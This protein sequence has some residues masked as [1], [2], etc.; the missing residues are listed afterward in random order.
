MV[1]VDAAAV[2]VSA[3][4]KV[5][6][7]GNR[8]ADARSPRYPA[9]LFPSVTA[10][11]DG[12]VVVAWLDNRFDPDPLWT[13]HTPPAGQP[14]SG[15]THPDNWQILAAVRTSGWS[16]PVAV[17][18]V[19]DAADRHPSVAAQSDGTL[20]AIWESKALQSS[21]ASLGLRSS[22]SADGGSTRSPFETVALE[23]TAMSQRARL[24]LDPDAAV[25]AVWYD[26]RASDWRW[27]VFTARYEAGWTA[28]QQLTSLGNGTFPSHGGGFVV[29][30]SD[31]AATR[32]QRD[33]TQQVYLLR[34]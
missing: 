10:G 12:R 17:S 24:S 31:R 26:T 22:R 9:S 28:R 29:F 1:G 13:G 25:R 15:G 19:T 32:T 33:P 4:G 8:A 11:P 16:S 34:L 5:I 30:T 3:A 21:G 27:K 14:A 6:D 18:A 2:N 7:A 20:V 23:P